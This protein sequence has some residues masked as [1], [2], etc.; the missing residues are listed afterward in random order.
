M[1]NNCLTHVCSVSI[2]EEKISL[3]DW[4]KLFE[5]SPLKDELPNE[6]FMEFCTDLYYI[7]YPEKGGEQ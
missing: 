2:P 1:S 4:L 7:R 6:E 3:D 5:A